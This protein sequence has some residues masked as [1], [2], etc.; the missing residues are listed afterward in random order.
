MKKRE[1]VLFVT[2]DGGGNLPPVLGLAQD[3]SESG[4]RVSVLSEPCMEDLIR[5]LGFNF[6]PFQRHFTRKDR[7]EDIFKDSNVSPIKNP[8]MENIVLGPVKTITEETMNATASKKPY[9]NI[10]IGPI[11]NNIRCISSLP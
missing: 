5:D 3:L 7:S 10:V 9:E 1:N 2:I 4:F 6:I 8:V 11:S